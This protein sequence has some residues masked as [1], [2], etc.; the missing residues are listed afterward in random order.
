M[1]SQDFVIYCKSYKNDI[2]RVAR[3]LESISAF[4]R[5]EIPV[6]VS[7]PVSDKDIFDEHLKK[8]SY[9]W[10]SDESVVAANPRLNQD[11]LASTRGGLTQQVIKSEFWRAVPCQSY[12]CIDSDSMFIKDFY[13]TD[14][15]A[16]DGHPYTVMQ[17]S[18][19]FLQHTI[20]VG[21]KEIAANFLSESE[22]LKKEFNRIGPD[23]DFGPSPYLWSAKV[24][25]AL[26]EQLLKP[27][28]KT[29]L[30]L[31]F[32][33]PPEN[34]WYG[35]ALLATSA[36]PLHPIENLFKVYH[37]EWQKKESEQFKETPEQLKRLYLGV[38][39]Q[40]NWDRSLD[41]SF[42]RKSWA[43]RSWKKVRSALNR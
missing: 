42:A 39:S 33:C 18:K 8:Y 9:T 20:N 17:Q 5:D 14:F 30:D 26:D 3:L 10:I 15:I 12:L 38:I 27:Q 1:K 23:Y 36:I 37:Y 16:L 21:K 2:L 40:S 11:L 24:W 32:H 34:R 25:A 4:N 35:E 41:P 6:Y 31:V 43:S 29:L 13:L 28:N 19:E 7:S 22:L